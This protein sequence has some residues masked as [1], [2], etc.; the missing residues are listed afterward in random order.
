[1]AK[2]KKK[3]AKMV[4]NPYWN[5]K[6]KREKKGRE[7]P[8]DQRSDVWIPHELRQKMAREREVEKKAAAKKKAKSKTKQ[9][10]PKAKGQ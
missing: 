9:A 6:P 7:K 3:P 10:R 5:G 4:P 8:L 1:M 2:A